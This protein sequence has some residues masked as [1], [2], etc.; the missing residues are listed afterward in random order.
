MFCF[1]HLILMAS[2]ELWLLL[3]IVIVP[4][5]TKV[6]LEELFVELIFGVMGLFCIL[7]SLVVTGRYYTSA[8][9]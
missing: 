5:L 9:S 7:L 3:L 8:F 6:S 4:L 1:W 2:G